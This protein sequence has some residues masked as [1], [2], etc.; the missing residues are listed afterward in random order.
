LEPHAVTIRVA[1]PAR[2]SDRRSMSIRGAY[3]GL[4][5]YNGHA[6]TTRSRYSPWLVWVAIAA[7]GDSTAPSDATTPPPDANI[8]AC[9]PIGAACGGS[10]QGTLE[11]VNSACVP[12]RG[13]CG[14][15]AG[16]ECQ[17]TSLTCTYPRG[18]S[19]GICMRADEK[20]CVCAIAPSTLGDCMPP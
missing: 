4:V 10:C 3:A 1:A 6:M 12:V 9:G 13:D 15:F 20:A 14:G 18:S 11:C 2:N 17:D 8:P 7:C 19:G 16:A 5:R